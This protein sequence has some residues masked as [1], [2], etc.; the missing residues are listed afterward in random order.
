VNRLLE[1]ATDHT[2]PLTWNARTLVPLCWCLALSAVLFRVQLN[3]PDL[4][5]VW[6][7]GTVVSLPQN[8][9]SD[10]YSA[11]L[12]VVNLRCTGTSAFWETRH[13]TEEV[14]WECQYAIAISNAWDLFLLG[15]PV[16]F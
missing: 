9:W 8:T 2:L 10:G 11:G 13:P 15:F 5:P 16:L 12:E 4:D 1:L 6:T 14:Q 7:I 3:G